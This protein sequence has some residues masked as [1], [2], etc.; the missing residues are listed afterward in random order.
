MEADE[1]SFLLLTKY[2]N[3]LPLEK[4]EK[5]EENNKTIYDILL[6]GYKIIIDEEV[7]IA[8]IKGLENNDIISFT[9]LPRHHKT[10]AIP[11]ITA[12]V[13]ANQICAL[14]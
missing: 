2:N 4:I 1:T 12:I 14:E 3:T 11:E 10:W 5:K 13:E 9:L 7:I 6:T 8:N